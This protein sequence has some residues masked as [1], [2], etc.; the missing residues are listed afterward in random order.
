VRWR[1]CAVADGQLW[2]VWDGGPTP[3]YQT[4]Y[5]HVF[6][7]LTASSQCV[8]EVAQG[9]WYIF[10]GNR[11]LEATRNTQYCRAQ[12]SSPENLNLHCFVPAREEIAL[13]SDLRSWACFDAEGATTYRQGNLAFT[14]AGNEVVSCIGSAR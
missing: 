2:P 6:E 4:L 3:A 7:G 9:T 12:F 1:G 10:A 8:A 5:T 13:T 14:A 11:S